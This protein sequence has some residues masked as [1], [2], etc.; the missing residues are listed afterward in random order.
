MDLRAHVGITQMTP[1]VT[2]PL[3]AMKVDDLVTSEVR[4]VMSSTV[5]EN[6]V[7]DSAVIPEHIQQRGQDGFRTHGPPAQ[8]RRYG[9]QGAIEL[10]VVYSSDLGFNFGFELG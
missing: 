10:R 7:R 1:Q 4:D 3:V 2:P 6:D 5:R 8:E 9:K